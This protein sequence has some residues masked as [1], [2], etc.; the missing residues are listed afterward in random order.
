MQK[1]RIIAS[2]LLGA[3]VACTMSAVG[4]AQTVD[5]GLP[6]R[7]KE[8]IESKWSMY[9]PEVYQG[10]AYDEVPVISTDKYTPGKVNINYLR[11]GLARANFYRYISGLPDNLE[12][13]EDYSKSAQYGAVISA[14]VYGNLTH[15]PRQ[16]AYM[17]NDFFY[18]AKSSAR[19]SNLITVDGS[20]G[21]K[22]AKAIDRYMGGSIFDLFKEEYYGSDKNGYGKDRLT[23]GPDLQLLHPYLKKI[24]IG[25]A[26]RN[27]Q[28][29]YAVL[30]FT[31]LS[32]R[33]V[34]N[35]SYIPY[36]AQ[37]DFPAD[38]F[39][40][41]QAWTIILSYSSF[42]N[43]TN[44]VYIELTRQ[45]D[46]YKWTTRSTDDSHLL[47]LNLQLGENSGERIH[48]QPKELDKIRDGDV[49]T[50]KVTGLR[51]SSDEPAELKYDVKFFY[52]NKPP[53]DLDDKEKPSSKP[54]VPEATVPADT[55]NTGAPNEKSSEIRF[56]DITGHWSESTVQWGITNGI[57]DGYTDG[58]FRPDSQVSEEEF[59]SM[60]LKAF[61]QKANS[62][63][64]AQWSDSLYTFA[65]QHKYP[66][67]GAENRAA[68]SQLI[69]R[70]SMAEIIAAADGAPLLKDKAIDYLLSKSYAEGRSNE[71]GIAGFAGQE[72]LTRAEALQLIRNVKE[73]GMKVLQ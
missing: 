67:K 42:S 46:Q 30:D 8:S 43:I 73:H 45:S 59:L 10:E 40:P 66:V 35:Y 41:N 58:K 29:S 38:V 72:G 18:T 22:T 26:S 19:G 12:L 54:P 55:G 47:Y 27:N 4:Y 2:L 9:N 33:D 68:R 71:S 25:L 60:L 56:S 51:T 53:V 20:R 64:G 52:I 11:G 7:T 16:P 62:T 50:V 61:D 31:D 14:A 13:E 1:K 6:I 15:E 39:S 34:F 23:Y 70:E 28:A 49:F 21:N 63:S 5:S 17:D 65:V 37:G 32:S 24:G 48:F 36:P 57:V 69:T 3:S 44:E